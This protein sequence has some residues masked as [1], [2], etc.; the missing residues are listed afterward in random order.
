MSVSPCGYT[1]AELEAQR[2]WRRVHRP[3]AVPGVV[4][5]D[6]LTV[7]LRASVARAR[8]AQVDPFVPAALRCGCAEEGR[9]ADCDQCLRHGHCG[10]CGECFCGALTYP[11][12]GCWLP[13]RA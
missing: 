2:Q 4:A 13:D 7:A 8:A 12:G 5:P 1:V 11:E 3:W 9:C 10:E 6:D